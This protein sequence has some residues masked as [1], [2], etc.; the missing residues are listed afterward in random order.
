MPELL[1]IR[2]AS[3]FASRHINKNVTTSNISHL[4][5]YGRIHKHGENGA[6]WVD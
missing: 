6:V 3:E 2:E 5:N 1:T 4:I